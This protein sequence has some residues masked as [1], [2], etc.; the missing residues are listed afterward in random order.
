[1]R[2]YTHTDFPIKTKIVA[3]YC[4]SQLIKIFQSYYVSTARELS[5][6]HFDKIAYLICESH[7]RNYPTISVIFASQNKHQRL[8][9]NNSV[10][11]I[12]QNAI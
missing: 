9:R 7:Q 11:N 12:K 8:L 4:Q 6:T 2:A 3:L 10:N 1:M 5:S